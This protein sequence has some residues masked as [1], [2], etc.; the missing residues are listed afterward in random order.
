MNVTAY[1]RRS[2]RAADHPGI[3]RTLDRPRAVRKVGLDACV[4]T[5]KSELGDQIRS[6]PSSAK[7]REGTLQGS[8]TVSVSQSFAVAERAE[9]PV[10][11]LLCS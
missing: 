11:A 2:P 7:T 5:E 6:L 8:A 9:D 4:T 10:L 1:G 3:N